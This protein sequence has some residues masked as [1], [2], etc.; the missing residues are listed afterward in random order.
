MDIHSLPQL[1]SCF[2]SAFL[3]FHVSFGVAAAVPITEG[4]L[5]IAAQSTP[6]PAQPT[7]LPAAGHTPA[8]TPASAIPHVPPPSASPTPHLAAAPPPAAPAP[9]D[10]KLLAGVASGV[11]SEVSGKPASSPGCVTTECVA[12]YPV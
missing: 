11:R 2:I 7:P 12:F 10:Q 1:V 6:P 5:V 3:F 9:V 8:Q 4:A